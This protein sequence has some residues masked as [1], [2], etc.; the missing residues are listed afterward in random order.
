MPR[1]KGGP[2][3]RQR[4]K[5]RLKKASG[6]WGGRHRLFRTATEA[7]DKAGVYAYRDRKQRK[8][9]FRRLWV[10]RINAASRLQGISYSQLMAGLKKAGIGLNR[11]V[12]ADLAV[13]DPKAFIAIAKKARGQIAAA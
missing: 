5:K 7:V 4:R 3:T 10:S 11:K 9:D 6:F 12:L 1:V 8:R 2:K 13:H